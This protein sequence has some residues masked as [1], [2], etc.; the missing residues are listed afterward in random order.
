M[1]FR[2]INLVHIFLIFF[3]NISFGQK[4]DSLTVKTKKVKILPVPAFGYEPETKFHF[5]AVSLFTIDLYQDAKTRLSNA[6]IE[7][8]Y[9]LR[10]QI[11][12]ESEWNY[13]F[14]EEKWFSDGLVHFAKYPDFFYGIGADVTENDKLLYESNRMILD[15]GLYK[16]LIDK[17]FFGGEIR[18]ANYSNISITE[19]NTSAELIDSWNFGLS[20]TIFYD[21][22]N[23]LL[24]ATKGSY[25]KLNLGYN[26]GTNHYTT[27]K[28]DAR[29][30]FTFKNNFVL[31]CRLYNSFVIGTPNFYDYSIL[32]GDEFVRGYF[33]GKY[34]DHNLSTFQAEVRTPL[35]WRLS[36]AFIT[37]ISTIYNNSNFARDLKPN[38]GVGI[39]FL[40][41]KEDN[42]NLRFD[43]VLGNNN[44]SG[45]YISFGESF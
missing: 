5:G 16:N 38:N 17:L 15:F 26:I 33:Y 21:S 44:N 39:R 34:R 8:N 23:N 28:L 11:I 36:L 7:F 42:V 37:G 32:G 18:Y 1:K 14:K 9:S 12:F 10:N 29:K 41:D 20:T 40:A 6:K 19:L 22:R 25:F 27:A 13:F 24:N 43:Y 4:T 2:L 3:S 35:F 31:A 45:F 30:Y